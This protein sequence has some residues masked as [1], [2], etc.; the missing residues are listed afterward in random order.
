MAFVRTNYHPTDK[1][2]FLGIT[3]RNKIGQHCGIKLSLSI[4]TVFW[5]MTS[6][7]Q[8]IISNQVLR[9]FSCLVYKRCPVFVPSF[10]CTNTINPLSVQGGKGR[11]HTEKYKE[12]YRPSMG[13]RYLSHYEFEQIKAWTCLGHKKNVRNPTT[14]LRLTER[15]IDD[16]WQGR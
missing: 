14:R 5:A 16:F 9:F 2:S 7:F 6:I 15:D 8:Y 11:T 12:N 10:W 1:V 4:N 13:E 3:I